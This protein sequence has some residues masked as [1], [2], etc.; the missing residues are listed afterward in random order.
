MPSITTRSATSP[1]TG[2][3]WRGARTAIALTILTSLLLACAPT[4]P[5]APTAAPAKPAEVAKPAA[6]AAAPPPPAPA[7]PAAAAA[8][9]RPTPKG[10]VTIATG[11]EPLM[12][13]AHDATASYNSQIMRNF[14]EALVN[15]DPKTQELVP[16]LATKWEQ[17]NP[18]TWRFT[19]RQGVKFH[20]G[21][22]FNAETAAEALNFM[23][24]KE[25]N[26]RIHG[27][28]GPEFTVKP[29]S[30][31]VIDV[32]LESPD[33]VLPPGCTSRRCI[34]RR[35]NGRRPTRPRSSRSGPAPT[36]SW[37]GSRASTSR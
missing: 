33:P 26:F 16:E 2:P 13:A 10:A 11:E 36:S 14:D 12:L 5:P 20:D 29:V 18:T 31:Y 1:R 24:A 23:W 15:R 9:T 30:E 21:S 19:L 8:P 3:D 28:I 27:R 22:P 37:S 32:V 6:P 17:T 35:P 7:A 4:A 34:R 25:N